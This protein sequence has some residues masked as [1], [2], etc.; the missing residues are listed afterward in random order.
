M[1]LGQTNSVI[2]VTRGVYQAATKQTSAA[3]PVAGLAAVP[4]YIEE[5]GRR[6]RERGGIPQY[7]LKLLWDPAYDIRDGDQ[8]TGYNPGHAALPPL[9]IVSH[10]GSS[11]IGTSRECRVAFLTALKPA[12]SST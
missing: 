10:A 12:G 11:G 9:L 5:I 8:I 2:G 4:V 6:I 1:A 7:D 3:A